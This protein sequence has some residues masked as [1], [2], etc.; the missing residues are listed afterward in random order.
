MRV[1]ARN[2]IAFVAIASAIAIGCGGAAASKS[3]GSPSND[4][5]EKVQEENAAPTGGTSAPSSTGTPG[6]Y[7]GPQPSPGP[8]PTFAEPPESPEMQRV[9]ARDALAR[10]EEDLAMST[11]R[12]CATACRALGSMERATARICDL[13]DTPDDRRKCDDA[14]KKLADAKQRIRASCSICSDGT[15]LD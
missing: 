11:R 12:D 7:P 15:K 13:A 1:P 6:T 5:H 14:K 9:R 8:A 10:A 4:S 3:P 2:G